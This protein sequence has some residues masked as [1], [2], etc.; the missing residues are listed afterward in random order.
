M[1]APIKEVPLQ[2]DRSD[3]NDQAWS[4]DQIGYRVNRFAMFLFWP[5]RCCPGFVDNAL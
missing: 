3:Q 4:P 5:S 1:L 2:D